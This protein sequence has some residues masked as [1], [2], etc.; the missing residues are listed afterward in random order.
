MDNEPISEVVILINDQPDSDPY[1]LPTGLG[2]MDQGLEAWIPFSSYDNAIDCLRIVL[3]NL[4]RMR[5]GESLFPDPV[6]E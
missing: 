2:W 5:D 1:E 3:R 4:E 6:V